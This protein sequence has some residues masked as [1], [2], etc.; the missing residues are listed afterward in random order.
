V[1]HLQD[2]VLSED[3]TLIVPNVTLEECRV[4]H[5]QLTDGPTTDKLTTLAQEGF[6]LLCQVNF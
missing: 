1:L 4:C 3:N 5:E 2:G 6:D